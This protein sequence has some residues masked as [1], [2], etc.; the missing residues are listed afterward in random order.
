MSIDDLTV[1]DAVGVDQMTDEVVLLLSD[2]LEWDPEQKH[3]DALR[4]KLNLYI[5]F[6]ESGEILQKF[7]DSVG[8]KCCVNVVMKFRPSSLGLQFLANASRTLDQAGIV[9]RWKYL[10]VGSG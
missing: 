3:I 8:R 10:E 2:H 1:V 4:E 9:L 7:P 5:R 6:I